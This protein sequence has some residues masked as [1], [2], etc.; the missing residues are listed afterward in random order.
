V[1]TRRTHHLG[2]ALARAGRTRLGRGQTAAVVL[3]L[4]ALAL[5]SAGCGGGSGANQARGVA[6]A[7]A[8]TR[9]TL[10]HSEFGKVIFVGRRVAYM[11]GPDKAGKSTCYGV[12]ASAW[13]PVTTKGAPSVSGLNASLL[14]TSK[15]RD[16]SLQVTYDHHPLYFF[17][18]DKPGKIMCQHAVMHGGIWLVVMRNGMPSMMKGKKMMK[19]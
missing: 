2:S 17:S 8:G 14:G 18:G 11:F 6:R 15:R 13:P 5:V 19:G 12:C 1:N 4:L 3:T 9:L 16:G 10:R 7:T